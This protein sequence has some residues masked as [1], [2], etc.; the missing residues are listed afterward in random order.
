MTHSIYTS[1]GLITLMRTELTDLDARTLHVCA[2]LSHT[3][4]S[5]TD[6][7]PPRS[8]AAEDVNVLPHVATVLLEQLPA[9]SPLLRA[10]VAR[11]KKGS[12]DHTVLASVPRI[13]P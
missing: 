13:T 9:N 7:R 5:V 11:P 12:R 10:A 4:T 6:L 1:K 8:Y 3:R 2:S